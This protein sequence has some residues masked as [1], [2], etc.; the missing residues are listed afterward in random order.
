MTNDNP[1]SRVRRIGSVSYLNAKPLIHG[2]DSDGD[3]DLELAVPAQLLEGLQSRRFDVALLPTI[4]YQRLSDA[5]IVPS[6]GIG[7]DGPTLTVRIF[8]RTPIDKMT[9]LACDV[10]SHSSVALARILL[11]ERY[12]ITP[13]LVDLPA[14]AADAPAMLLIGDKVVLDAP[15]GMDYQLDLGAAWKELTRMPFVF[16]VWVARRGTDLGDLPERCSAPGSAAWPICR[17]SSPATP[18]RAAGPRIW[19]CNTCPLI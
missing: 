2:L 9:T 18:S 6:G 7:C 15:A 16:A 1:P 3:V 12:G 5:R 17:T 8:S 14:E 19:P 10:E 11:A 4:D 13:R